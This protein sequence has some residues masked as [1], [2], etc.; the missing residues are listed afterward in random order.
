[1]RAGGGEIAKQRQS[2]QIAS[3]W[4][5]QRDLAAFRHFERALGAD[6]EQSGVLG[7]IDLD[8]DRAGAEISEVEARIENT[9]VRHAERQPA[10]EGNDGASVYRPTKAVEHRPQGALFQQE[11]ARLPSKRAIDGAR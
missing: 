3:G 6:P 7:G 10:R 4:K 8:I 5:D 1:M 11:G 2:L 9:A